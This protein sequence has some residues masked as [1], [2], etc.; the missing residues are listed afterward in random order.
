MKVSD[1]VVFDTVTDKPLKVKV[2]LMDYLTLEY[3]KEYT[4]EHIL[5]AFCSTV[6]ISEKIQELKEKIPKMFKDLNKTKSARE[7]VL[8]ALAPELE[9][10]KKY[11]DMLDPEE[12]QRFV[13][14]MLASR[15]SQ[16]NVLSF[17]H[18][19]ENDFVRSIKDDIL[20]RW[21]KFKMNLAFVDQKVV[22]ATLFV[23]FMGLIN[24]HLDNLLYEKL[25][26]SYLESELKKSW[27]SAVDILE[28]IEEYKVF[29]FNN[30]KRLDDVSNIEHRT[31]LSVREDVLKSI[32]EG[33]TLA[34][35]N[36][37]EKKNV[38]D[39]IFPDF[40]KECVNALLKYMKRKDNDSL[41]IMDIDIKSFLS[42]EKRL[43]LIDWNKLYETAFEKSEDNENVNIKIDLQN[44]SLF[45]FFNN[46]K[47]DVKLYSLDLEK[48]TVFS[49]NSLKKIRYLEKVSSNENVDK[50]LN[51][52]LKSVEIDNLNSYLESAVNCF[53]FVKR[54]L[55]NNNYLVDFAIKIDEERKS[56]PY[57]YISAPLI[58]KPL[59]ERLMKERVFN[60]QIGHDYDNIV[61]E[62]LMRID[63]VT[64]KTTPK[65]STIKKF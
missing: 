49:V 30:P 38:L 43:S 56:H 10:V 16:T 24:N 60:P 8:S 7:Y 9:E 32:T 50:E 46:K 52:Y 28:S 63:L 55:E 26:L 1:K 45:F 19:M 62:E 5:S 54:A 12:K 20:P 18:T 59:I 61:E 47:S 27:Y 25:D 22:P 21:S 34:H 4:L 41:Y 37:L 11:V 17:A 36:F 35:S 33:K 3:G 64:S 51:E 48:Y 6:R 31:Y 15:L 14:I 58:A 13:K 65:K 44:Y 57:L 23:S 42:D 2:D 53:N 29:Y 40:N 39:K